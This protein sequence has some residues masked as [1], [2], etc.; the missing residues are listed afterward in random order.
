MND[1]VVMVL[2]L[3]ATRACIKINMIQAKLHCHMRWIVFDAYCSMRPEN[4]DNLTES[5]LP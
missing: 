4:K 1:I 2:L 5:S 3:L